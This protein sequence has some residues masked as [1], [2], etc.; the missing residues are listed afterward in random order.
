MHLEKKIPAWWGL[1]AAPTQVDCLLTDK[2]SDR[3]GTFV[4]GFPPSD[5][6]R[7]GRQVVEDPQT[8]LDSAVT[9]TIPQAWRCPPTDLIWHDWNNDQFSKGQW[10]VWSAGQFEQL[11]ALQDDVDISPELTMASADWADGWT[12]FIDGAISQGRR[13]AARVLSIARVNVHKL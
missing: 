13:A 4:V 9:S 7:A 3:D 1:A 8:F 11:K 6:H 2:Y 5:A 10:A 12:G